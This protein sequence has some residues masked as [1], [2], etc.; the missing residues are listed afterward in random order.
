ME[1]FIPIIGVAVGVL[2][3]IGVAWVWLKSKIPHAE[4]KVRAELNPQLAV[5][6]ANLNA[7]S[8]QKETLEASFRR[9]NAEFGALRDQLQGEVSKRAAAE[10]QARRIPELE[11]HL[12]QRE[13]RVE[14]LQDER[15]ALT[16]RLS[17]TEMA[18]KKEQKA[19]AEKLALLDEAQTKLSDAFQSLSAQALQKNNQSFL[20]LARE[21]LAKFQ[22][23]AQGDLSSRQKA[24]DELVKPLRESLEKVNVRI[25]EVE[26]ERTSAYASLSEQVKSLATTES[27]LQAETANLVK[28]LRSPIVRGRWGEIQ[29]Q[30]VV[31]LA[32]MLEHCDF[33][34]QES[35]DTEAGRLR[36]DMVI[37]LPNQKN[38]VVDSKVS[39][40]AY[41]EALETENEGEKRACLK[42]HARQVRKHINDLGAKAYWSQFSPT[43]EFVVLFLPGEPFF[44]AA[45]E[46]DPSLIEAGV[47]KKVILATPTTLIALLQAVAY[48]WRHEQLAENAQEISQLG[49]Q[50]YERIR[51]LAMHFDD[52]KKGIE[53]ASG[54]YNKAVG[55][56]E[57]RVLV[58]VRKFKELGASRGD[59][60][61][62]IEPVEHATRQLNADELNALPDETPAEKDTEA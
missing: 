13:N 17:E 49:V 58:T 8:E 20:E 28:A 43:P 18:M 36:P 54:A 33:V 42:N 11:A 2:L 50:L 5:A 57:S 19:A 46:Q 34:Q 30:R 14:A 45:L 51:T 27:R 61:P 38:I 24:I 35:V 10:E 1:A 7:L 39:L 21:N 53:R 52:M 12:E 23:T 32:G 25:G 31:E 44:S 40:Q 60:I 47:E 26:K 16:S 37:K 62:T 15:T 3:G 55:T 9:A 29:L 59:D 6:Q 48:G 56:L 22:S 41:L 4:E